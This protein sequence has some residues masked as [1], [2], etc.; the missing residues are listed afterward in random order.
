MFWWGV[1]RY[2]GGNPTSYDD[3]V[4]GFPAY[5][6]RGVLGVLYEWPH[7]DVCLGDDVGMNLRVEEKVMEQVC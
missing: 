3:V 2:G 1:L 7:G 4:V 6:V 5:L